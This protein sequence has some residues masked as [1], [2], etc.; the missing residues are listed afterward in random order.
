MKNLTAVLL[1]AHGAPESLDEVS[2]YL[3]NIMGRSPSK[4]VIDEIK[5]R[6][7]LAGGKSPLLEITQQQA[8]ALEKSLNQNGKKFKVYIGMRH[9]HPF[10]HETVK[11]ITADQPE[12]LL[13]LSLAPHYSKLS[14]GAYLQTLNE[15]LS[16]ADL[17][18]PVHEVKSWAVEPALIA[19]FKEHIQ[20]EL[21]QYKDAM[22]HSLCLLFTAHSLPESVIKEGDPY[23]DEVRATVSAIVER[24]DLKTPIIPWFFAYQSQGLR[25]GKWLGPSVEETLGNL[26]EAG[27]SHLVVAPIG[28]V[29]DHIEILYDVDIH[30]KGLAAS[31]GITLK[32]IP[33]LNTTPLFIKALSNVIQSHLPKST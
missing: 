3:R 30:F 18:I 21:A 24:L 22:R 12:R 20:N 16:A 23:P 32:R 1:M 29:S 2:P 31:Q 9:W 17:D 15:A 26:G 8:T 11:Q 25:P 33:S 4:E 5:E 7:R 14:V 10:I 6:Y 13:A 28:F 27:C 19:A